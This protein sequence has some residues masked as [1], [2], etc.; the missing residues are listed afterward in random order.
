M[1]I[2]SPTLRVHVV[3]D[4]DNGA[5]II[6][7]IAKRL[8]EHAPA[9]GIDAT[10]SNKP[11]DDVDLNHWM[12]YAFANVA[13]A[14][15]TTMFIT[16]LDDPYKVSL[17]RGEL[18]SGV[19]VGICMSS[20]AVEE[21]VG[22]GI[23]RESLAYV[24]PAHDSSV[25]PRRIV[26]GLTTRLYPDGRKREAMIVELARRMRLDAFRFDIYG[27]GWEKVV[28]RIVEAGAEVRYFDDTGDYVSNYRRIVEAIPSFDYYL[29]LGW[30]EGSLGTL[31][32]LS[33]GVKTIVTP[34]GF[35]VDLPH[36]ITHAVRDIEDLH[37]VFREIAEDR[38]ARISS[39]SG[40]T[41][42]EHTREHAVIWRAV[43]AGRKA[44]IPSLL[45]RTAQPRFAPPPAD[46]ERQ[47]RMRVLSPV[48][49]RSALSHV[50]LLKP[51]RR[52]IVDRIR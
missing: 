32:A 45:G 49:L 7:K 35:H 30:D 52:W 5:W 42:A 20:Y 28:P 19:A 26:I 15:P 13:H 25:T 8:V 50:P 22:R 4:D 1:D 29:Y 47:Y 21:L 48:R 11:R 9:F 36:G 12:S 23:P 3:L 18:S 37:A 27:Q 16:H 40:L 6:D 43:A 10:L 34:Q 41:W 44:E 17:V 38:K 33:A 51:L 46:I 2:A 24:L 39:V 14:T 31:D